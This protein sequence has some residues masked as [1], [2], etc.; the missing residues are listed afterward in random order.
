MDRKLL[1]L[2]LI[3]TT[4]VAEVTDNL[5]TDQWDVDGNVQTNPDGSFVFS[6]TEGTVSQTV[7][8]SEYDQIDSISVGG[9]SLGCNNF[10]GGQ[11][12]STNPAYYDQI[13]V[14]LTYGEESWQETYT[15]DYNAG[16]IDY[17]MEVTPTGSADTAL[18]E[19]TS[20]DPGFWGGYYASYTVDPYLTVAHSEAAPVVPV[21][22]VIPEVPEVPVVPEIPEVALPEPIPELAPTEDPVLQTTVLDS[23][24]TPVELPT[25][26]V[27]TAEVEIPT[28]E[29]EAPVE[30]PQMDSSPVEAPQPE[31]QESPS[32]SPQERPSGPTAIV[33]T[34]MTLDVAS[35]DMEA[36]G[37]AAGDPASPVAQ[38]LAL[39]VMAAQG[40]EIEDVE[41][42]QPELPKGPEIRDNRNLADRYWIGRMADDAKFDK[43]MVEAQWQK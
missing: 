42:L 28:V 9:S 16:F 23:V 21:A 1:P 32:E 6:F 43:Y 41:L 36:I 37:D 15:L 12:S 2:L 11:C 27:V 22:P 10:I 25:V 8:L 17:G 24:I 4:A 5:L 29:V 14:T 35:A 33:S 34:M 3:A 18:L 39:A 13:T 19:F 7:D 38:V 26:D 30:A 40:A 20:I 31:S